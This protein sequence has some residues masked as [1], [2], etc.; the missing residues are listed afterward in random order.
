MSSTG[1]VSVI[2]PCYNAAQT[3]EKA[4]ESVL[5]QTHTNWEL[6]LLE[7]GSCDE[8]LSKARQLATSDSR[9]KL[10]ASAA[11]RGVIRMRNIGIRLAS[12]DWIAFCDAD[13]W[14]QPDKLE[15]QLLKARQTDAN[16]VYSAVYYIRERKRSIRQKEVQ[17]LPDVNYQAMLKTNAIPMSS[18]IYAVDKLGK[19]Y[20]SNM[21]DGLVHEDYAY[22]LRLFRNGPVKAAYLRQP[23]TFIRLQKQSRSSNLL[24]AARSQ[25]AILGNE[26]TLSE[27][28]I[29]LNMLYYTATAVR[30]RLPWYGWKIANHH[31]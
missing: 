13:D 24:R 30:K 3:L 8:S 10:I 5:A 15:I 27:L 25:A 19:K 28:Q 18:A 21:K 17:L 1:L 7:D 2:M 16:L 20:F 6:L 4:V 11:N 31:K 12:G 23:T 22:W 29:I 14:W 26:N 9:I